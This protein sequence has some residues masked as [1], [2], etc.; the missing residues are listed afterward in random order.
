MSTMELR[1]CFKIFSIGGEGR[2]CTWHTLPPPCIDLPRVPVTTHP[3][4]RFNL[5][6]DILENTGTKF[7]QFN[8]CLPLSV[9]YLLQLALSLSIPSVAVSPTLSVL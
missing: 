1:I 6:T 3:V 7:K 5:V 2:G 8:V 9:S 4:S